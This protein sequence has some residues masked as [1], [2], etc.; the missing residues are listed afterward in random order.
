MA[1]EGTLALT[2]VIELAASMGGLPLRVVRVEELDSV[3]DQVLGV[4][5]S[6][7][8]S[9]REG[10]SQPN[11]SFTSRSIRWEMTNRT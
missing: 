10:L 8:G 9:A 4:T 6:E 1:N 2:F 5:P 3:D 7:V 11:R